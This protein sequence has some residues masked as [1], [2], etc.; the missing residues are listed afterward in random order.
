MM[1]KVHEIIESSY[2]A[3]KSTQQNTV[4]SNAL[5]MMEHRIIIVVVAKMWCPVWQSKK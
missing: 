2:F 4:D 1:E 5:H 3:V